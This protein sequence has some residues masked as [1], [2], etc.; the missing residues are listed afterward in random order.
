MGRSTRSAAAAR[1][2][3]AR[4]GP[5]ATTLTKRE[6]RWAKRIR[7]TASKAAVLKRIQRLSATLGRT[8]IRDCSNTATDTVLKNALALIPLEVTETSL[9][10]L[11]KRSTRSFFPPP[12]TGQNPRR[13]QLPDAL[14]D[15][16]VMGAIWIADRFTSS[17]HTPRMV[18]DRLARRC[19]R[20]KENARRDA[21]YKPP[22]ND[23]PVDIFLYIIHEFLLGHDVS[24]FG[25]R[26]LTLPR[27]CP[28]NSVAQDV[29]HGCHF[30]RSAVR[31][32]GVSHKFRHAVIGSGYLTRLHVHWRMHTAAGELA[33]PPPVGTGLGLFRSVRR[34]A[35]GSAVSSFREMG[36]VV[37]RAVDTFHMIYHIPCAMLAEEPAVQM[38]EFLHKVLTVAVR[39]RPS[40]PTSS[41]R[42]F[43]DRNTATTLILHL[44]GVFDWPLLAQEVGDP[45]TAFDI[46]RSR[47]AWSGLMELM[48]CFE[49]DLTWMLAAVHGAYSYFCRRRPRRKLAR[50]ILRHLLRQAPPY[51]PDYDPYATGSS[52]ARQ[53]QPEYKV[54]E[55]V[56]KD[57]ILVWLVG[58]HVPRTFSEYYVQRRAQRYLRH[59]AREMRD[60]AATAAAA[61]AI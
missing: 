29:F 43:A 58:Q 60:A 54:D 4:R 37:D 46:Q 13:G 42:V 11:S 19:A 44:R 10:S 36:T 7:S 59:R 41:T 6:V 12:T 57:L 53:E 23:I 26:D 21:L 9:L 20:R 52:Q 55:H 15:G 24:H 34:D 2:A 39:R 27:G 33:I 61:T 3:T 38:F 48:A 51:I 1:S 50:R 16:R 32:A 31:L 47:R 56:D 14:S 40:S 18:C 8:S 35:V 49:Y 5:R 25:H 22:L 45:A 28:V 30:L 17:Y